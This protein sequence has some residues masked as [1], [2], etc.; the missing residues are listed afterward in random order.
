MTADGAPPPHP[1]L[2]VLVTRPPPG[3]DETM[4]ALVALGHRP[5]AAPLLRVRPLSPAMPGRAQAILLTSGQAAEP[6]A[7]AAPHLRDAP[8]LAVGDRTAARARDAGF[9]QIGSAGGD[10][11]D[12]AALVAARCRPTDG[13]LLLA[14]GAG[15]GL[16]L[17]RTLRAASFRINRRCV[18]E[19]QSV[20]RLPGSALEAL[21]SAARLDVAL[22]FSRETAAVF[23]RLLSPRLQPALVMTRAAVIS[24]SAAEPLL[25]L[26]WRLVEIA[27][28]PDAPS[29]LSL[30]DPA[31]VS[32]ECS[33]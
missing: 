15:H 28:A 16:P 24:H 26:G 1:G 7:A 10:A 33:R 29:L 27:S 21:N 5:I 30:L 14:C 25:G 22:F 23:A 32:P 2:S 3:L 12:L 20:R 6:L 18:Y 4:R 9:R 8:L 19:A 31:S 17:C 13:P 11:N